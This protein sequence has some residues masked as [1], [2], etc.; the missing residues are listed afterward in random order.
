MKLFR[1]IQLVRQTAT[2]FVALAAITGVAT[3]PLVA[4]STQGGVRGA[5]TDQTGA[6]VANAKV[7]LINDGTNETRSLVTNSEGGYDFNLVVPATYTITAE[8]PS[9]KK[10]S[11]KNVIIATQE[12]LTVDLKLEVGSVTESVLV[13][14]E[15]PLVETAN[16]SQGQVLDNQKLI[17]LPNLGRNPFMMSK[18][19]QNVMNVGPPAYNRMEDQSGSSM[20]SIAGGPVRGNNYL[21]DGIPITDANN[22][23]IIIPTIEAVQEV[24]IQSNTYDAEMARTGGGMFNTLMKSGTNDFHG[25][26]YGALRRTSW[27]ANNFFSN[28]A[29]IPITDQPNTT[30]GASFGGPVW[31]PKVYNGRNKTFFFLGVEHY[32]DTQSNSATFAEPTALERVGNFSQTV[33]PA[34]TSFI[35]PATGA[36]YPGNIIPANQL[37]SVGLNIAQQFPLPATAPSHYGANDLT[38]ASTI[39]ARAVQYTAKV[40]EDFFSWWRASVSY[41]QY[42]SLEPGDTWFNSPSTTDG[43]RLLRRVNATQLNNFFTIDP[44]TVLAVRYGFNRF[45]NYDYNSSQGYN[46]GN[47]GF[48]PSYVASINP[49]LAEFPAISLTSFHNLGESGDND[50]Y[51]EASNNFGTSVDKYIGKHSL[52]FGFD[53]RKLKTS[54]SGVSCP[55]G[56]YGFNTNTPG[57]NSYTGLDIGDLLIGAPYTR[58]AD[59]TTTLT[60]YVNYYGLYIQD[61][62]RLSSKITLNY[63]LR[64]EHESGIK[65]INNGLL[66]NFNETVPNVLASQVTGIQPVGAVEYAGLNGNTTQTGDFNT[67]KWGPRG[68]IAYQFDSKTVIRGGYG[69]FWAP[70]FALGGPISTL[71]YSQTTSFTGSTN[72]AGALTPTLY[73]PFPGGLIPPNGNSLGVAAGIGQDFSLPDPTAKS[74]RVQQYSVDIQRQLPYGIAAEVGY[75]GSYSTHMILGAPQININAL[76]PSLLSQGTAALNALVPNPYFGHI[77]NGSLAAAN[78]PAYFLQL[79]FSTYGKIDEIFSDQNRAKYNSMV[80]KVQKRLSQGLTFLSTMTWSKNQDESSGG[81]GNSLNGGAQGYPQNPYDMAAEYALANINSPIRWAFAV[82][83]TLPFGAGKPFLNSS[84][85]MDYVVGGWTYNAVAVYQTGFPLQIYQNDANGQY[86]YQAQRPN[87]T[88]VNPAVSGSVESK[89]YNYFNVDSFSAAPQGTFGNL[90]RTIPLRGPGQ[91]NWDMSLFKTVMIKERFQAQFRLEMLNAL[92]SPLFASPDTN[93]SDTGSFGVVNTQSNFARQLQM[94]LR[95]SF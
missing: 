44:T 93:Q 54:G 55:T 62:F 36:P 2:L 20:I 78:V 79:P 16:A 30:W 32:D 41:L 85:W 88:G 10:M 45:P 65:E 91:K 92:N 39:K 6:G 40:D 86:G 82:S 52:K 15:V 77:T 21:L 76:N 81:P 80:V 58:S 4:Q 75:V 89:I 59:N 43:W 17:D 46:I 5:V 7:S 66:V 71:G 56:C 3:I 50:Y 35:N 11:R 8:A 25:S 90:S 60:D 42:Y 68:G 24:K 64:W 95:F 73:S 94:A 9:F 19:S 34:G 49:A 57:S 69:L 18:L 83:Y 74:P 37:S 53:W 51:S 23:A 26:A 84:K 48:D 28:A 14:E 29:G 31:I 70:Q 1:S 12:Y 13:T 33:F 67:N 72:L 27:D 22:R 87:Y 38:A 63:G 47:L 61:N